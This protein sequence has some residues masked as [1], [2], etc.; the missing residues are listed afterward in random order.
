MAR[1]RG[2]AL[3]RTLVGLDRTQRAEALAARSGDTRV[4]WKSAGSHKG[5]CD[6]WRGGVALGSYDDAAV[7]EFGVVDDARGRGEVHWSSI[8]G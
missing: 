3:S 4:N 6:I 1:G 8:S 7:R 2:E 5:E